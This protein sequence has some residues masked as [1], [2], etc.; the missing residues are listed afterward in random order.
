MERV[1]HRPRQPGVRHLRHHPLNLRRSSLNTNAI[2]EDAPPPEL[3]LRLRR[4]GGRGSVRGSPC[5][6][7]ARLR[8][9]SLRPPSCG[10]SA[11]PSRCAPRFSYY[12]GTPGSATYQGVGRPP[13]IRYSAGGLPARIRPRGS[14]GLSS[15]RATRPS[16]SLLRY[17]SIKER[18]S[19]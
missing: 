15:E 19:P 12:G 11:G 10:D 17:P 2:P 14:P 9:T 18:S 13:N 4:L 7:P 1:R 5:G 6:E 8:F 3:T 16:P